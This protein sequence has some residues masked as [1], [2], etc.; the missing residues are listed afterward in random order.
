MGRETVP[1]FSMANRTVWSLEAHA[2]CHDCDWVS[3]YEK[4]QGS[5]TVKDVCAQAAL[6]TN[7]KGHTTAVEN[8]KMIKYSPGV[9][10]VF[11]F[12]EINHP[13]CDNHP[14]ID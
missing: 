11:G 12:M 9:E 3:D 5:D 13:I 1:I 4:W 7:A 6:H 10:D 2:Y 14:E 8:M